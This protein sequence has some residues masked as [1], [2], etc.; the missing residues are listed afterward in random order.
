MSNSRWRWLLPIAVVLVAALAARTM[1]ASRDELPRRAVEP[2]VPVVEVVPVELGSVAVRIRSQGTVQPRKQISLVSEVAGRVIWTAPE[3][4]EGGLVTQDAILL[5]IDPIDYEV[6]VSD[7][8]AAVASAEF[9]LAEN[10]ALLKRAGIEEAEA[11]LAAA[12]DRLRQAKADLEKTTV[13]APFAAVIDQRQVDLGQ[14]VS[15]GTVLMNLLGTEVAKVRLPVLA[16]DLPFLQAGQLDD[17]SWPAVRLSS[18]FGRQTF[19]WQGRLARL[20]N[21]VDAETRVS[22]LVAEVDQPYRREVHGQPLSLGLF[23]TAEIEGSS[24]AAAV[25]LPRSVLHRGD[26]VFV[27]EE[28]VLRQRP[29][30]VV[31]V[32]EGGVIVDDGLQNGDQVV[33]SRLDLMVEA[34]PVAVAD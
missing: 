31:R 15:P 29:V 5:R 28:G 34:M 2:P 13:T 9:S 8:R 24:V 30:R 10:R 26:R 33:R 6:A 17:G 25:R 18:Q 20:E 14:Y 23:V 19:S 22:Y 11:K 3:Y 21:R 4:R 16:E 27:V 1:I 32:E 12:R 7:A